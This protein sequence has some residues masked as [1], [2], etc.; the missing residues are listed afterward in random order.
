MRSADRIRS[1][2]PESHA[3]DR[4]PG[5]RVVANLPCAAGGTTAQGRGLGRGG[6][7]AHQ[8]FEDDG[9]GERLALGHK[10]HLQEWRPGISNSPD[11]V[12][13]ALT[14]LGPGAASLSRVQFGECS[15]LRPER[16]ICRKRATTKPPNPVGATVDAV[17]DG[18]RCLSRDGF[19]FTMMFKQC[20]T[21]SATA[22]PLNNH[23]HCLA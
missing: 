2:T 1:H 14:T 6:S 4:S 7:G 21:G 18:G 8:L 15:K 20:P 23:R 10:E 5:D 9:D 16:N 11:Q 19:R 3:G 12:G 22:A 17:T 13:I